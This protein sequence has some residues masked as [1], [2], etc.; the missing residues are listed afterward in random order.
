MKRLRVCARYFIFILTIVLLAAICPVGKCQAQD[1]VSGSSFMEKTHLGLGVGITQL[2]GEGSFK[3]RKYPSFEAYLDHEIT[4]KINLKGVIFYTNVGGTTGLMYNPAAP[5]DVPIGSIVPQGQY[6]YTF[7]S[8]IF[9]LSFVPQYNFRDITEGKKWT[10]YVFAGVSFYHFNRYFVF[11]DG[12]KEP[13]GIYLPAGAPP[14]GSNGK[15]NSSTLINV[16]VGIGIKY[17]MTRFI[18]IY[19]EFS[20]R[21]LFTDYIDGYGST[22]LF[23]NNSNDYYYTV[24]LGMYFRL[25]GFETSLFKRKNKKST[26]DK[27]GGKSFSRKGCPP[28][29]L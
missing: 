28:V 1:N 10:P 7:K 25:G 5:P 14:S 23:Q 16:P 19:G 4:H 8:R 29:Y 3:Y 12:K 27:I 9:E 6:P 26:E 15:A 17:S 20:R 13:G 11:P 18:G 24:M 2:G 21:I 22:D